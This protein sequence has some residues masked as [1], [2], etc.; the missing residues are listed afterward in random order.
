[1]Q[2]TSR[3]LISFLFLFCVIRVGAQGNDIKKERIKSPFFKGVTVHLDVAS[4]VNNLVST[5]ETY[6]MEG[7]LQANIK[8]K[9][10]PIVEIGWAGANKMTTD[11]IGFKTNG[12]FG[13]VGV[14]FNIIKPTDKT[15]PVKNFFLVGARLG[16]T[17]FSYDISSIGIID[18]YWGSKSVINYNNQT[19]TKAWY[20][21]VVG[22][23]VEII[24]RV[25]V[26][27]KVRNKH[28]INKNEEGKV[29]PWFVPGFGKVASNPWG[30]NYT[31]GYQF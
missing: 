21:I 31:I 12:L 22:V 25:Y 27:W 7:G 9:Y 20:E 18:D 29:S 15:K 8:N 10:L 4:L 13:K 26:G 6:S 30:L 19:S 14:D 11:N 24:H 23:K 17:N 28:L 3:Y 1:M 16:L 5:G 2:K